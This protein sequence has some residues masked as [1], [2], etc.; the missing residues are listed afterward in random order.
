MIKRVSAAQLG[1]SK[2][3]K[4]DVGYPYSEKWNFL[5]CLHVN[6]TSDREFKLIHV[7]GADIEKTPLDSLFDPE[8]LSFSAVSLASNHEQTARWE[9]QRHSGNCLDCMMPVLCLP[10]GIVYSV[11]YNISIRGEF[12]SMFYRTV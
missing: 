12:I 4:G 1:L 9:F 6:M 2:L 5:L 10:H 8:I 11:E 3:G 7:S